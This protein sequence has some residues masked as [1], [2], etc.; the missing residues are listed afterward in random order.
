ML[1]LPRP[2]ISSG[3]PEGPGVAFSGL[4]AGGS[5]RLAAW[6]YLTTRLL[7]ESCESSLDRDLPARSSSGPGS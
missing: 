5:L 4:P 2:V 6:P 1:E 3:V 7:I